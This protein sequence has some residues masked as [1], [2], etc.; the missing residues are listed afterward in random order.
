V[1]DEKLTEAMRSLLGAAQPVT[2]LG[3]DARKGFLSGLAKP[4]TSRGMKRGEGQRLVF[5]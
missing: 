2:V 3:V 5:E 1:G 4:H